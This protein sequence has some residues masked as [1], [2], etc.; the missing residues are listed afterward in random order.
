MFY[1]RIGVA[2]VVIAAS[3][4]SKEPAQKVEAE[5]EAEP[6]GQEESEAPV[7][8]AEAVSEA[9]LPDIEESILAQ[10]RA[11]QTRKCIRPV[12]RGAARPGA[13]DDDVLA[14]LDPAGAHAGCYAAIDGKEM[15][16]RAAW[17]PDGTKG[18][19]RAARP[20]DHAQAWDAAASAIASACDGV[21][22]ALARAVSHEDACS[23]YLPGRRGQGALKSFVSLAW[24]TMAKARERAR[25]G[26]VRGAIELLLDY[27][28][29]GQD[30]GRGGSSFT[31]AMLAAV[32]LRL[33][34][35]DIGML[36]GSPALDA[37]DLEA[38]G[39]QLERLLASEVHPS[40]FLHAKKLELALYSLLPLLHGRDWV[41][42][43]GFPAEHVAPADAENQDE[44]GAAEARFA[45]MGLIVAEELDRDLAQRCPAQAGLRQCVDGLQARVRLAAEA[46][47]M[48]PVA[49]DGDPT[50][51]HGEERRQ[52]LDV[53]GNASAALDLKYV[54]HQAWRTAALEG[55]RIAVASRLSLLGGGPCPH[56]AGV[57]SDRL[58][59]DITIEGAG[60]AHTVLAPVWLEEASGQTSS[61]ASS[62]RILDIAC[63]P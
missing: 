61:D 45:R 23:P 42:P 26:D 14:L 9:D 36:L 8:A 56:R 12:L 55:F 30:F 40:A 10:A 16:L 31:E 15:D 46:A 1:F 43:G 50:R 3:A 52:V 58:G 63:T 4:C 57:A 18:S 19:I 5:T 22:D 6:A 25:L 41:P 48:P 28:R 33:V 49:A 2:A 20:L 13:A 53:M 37:G 35:A 17:Q 44:L 38:L 34:A 47:A 11:N 21:P 39:E 54:L 60:A 62:R 51:L 7:A 32:T 27:V 59:G 24:A 29:L